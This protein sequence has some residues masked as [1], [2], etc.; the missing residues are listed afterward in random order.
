MLG[1]F[2]LSIKKNI[3]RI[4]KSLYW[5][6]LYKTD[7]FQW[8]VEKA[9]SWGAKIGEGCKLYSIDFLD[10]PYLVELGNHVVVADAV[11]F[12]THDGGVWLF[13]DKHPEIDNYGKIVVKDNVFI[14][15][16]TIILAGATIGNNCVIGAGSV[17][18][19]KIPDNSVVLGNPA[20]V[21]MKFSLYKKLILNSKTTLPTALIPKT[22]EGK[23]KRYEMISRAF[24]LE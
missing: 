16:N 21:V 7:I 12:I 3:R 23:K 18:R 20:K 24:N 4:R 14:G 1:G 10:E 13:W 19:G 5:R 6:S 11:R 22:V 15:M 2:F 17:V 9:R 8:R